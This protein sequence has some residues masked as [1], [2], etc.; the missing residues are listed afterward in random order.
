MDFR[1]VCLAPNGSLSGPA[2]ARIVRHMK[3]R[4][5]AAILW[6]YAGWFVGA[7]LAFMLGL[8]P[9]LAPIVATAAA[10]LVA[11]DPRR[12]IWT[13]RTSSGPRARIRFAHPA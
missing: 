7:V 2:R 12:L 1:M 3:K 10:A 4:I 5:T 8:S 13:Q 6:F 9:A 11:G